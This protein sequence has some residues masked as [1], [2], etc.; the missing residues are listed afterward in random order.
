MIKKIFYGSSFFI[1]FIISGLYSS[2]KSES[3]NNRPAI[4]YIENNFWYEIANMLLTLSIILIILFSLIWIMKKMQSSRIKF[5]ND[6]S[7]IK[8][9]DHRP[10]SAKTGLYLIEVKGKEILI[11]DSPTGVTYLTDL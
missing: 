5:H 7:L 8:I 1:L 4:E 6:S 3:D 11:S 9:I 2:E 10:L